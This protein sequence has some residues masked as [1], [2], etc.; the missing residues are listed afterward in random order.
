M[1]LTL[2]SSFFTQ[3][4]CTQDKQQGAPDEGA[5]LLLVF[6]SCYTGTHRVGVHP[7]SASWPH[8]FYITPH[9]LGYMQ[10]PTCAQPPCFKI[11]NITISFKLMKDGIAPQWLADGISESSMLVVAKL[12]KLQLLQGR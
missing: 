11:G 12:A 3:H 10:H 9:P 7:L 5:R 1:V 8:P 4:V 6:Y 2:H